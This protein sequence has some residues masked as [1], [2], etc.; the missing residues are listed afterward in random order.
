MLRINFFLRGAIFLVEVN[1]HPQVVQARLHFFKGVGPDFL[2]A[3]LFEL[4][5]GFFRVIPKARSGCFTLLKLYF[6]K[7]TINVKDASLT[8]PGDHPVT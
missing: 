5:L 1:K 8:H 4:F 7:L 3:D 2:V 6:G